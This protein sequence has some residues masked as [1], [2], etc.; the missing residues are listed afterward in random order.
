MKKVLAIAS[1]LAL[2]VLSSAKLN[3]VRI[4]QYLKISNRVI[5]NG[6]TVVRSSLD[7][8]VA[9]KS[10]TLLGTIDEYGNRRTEDSIFIGSMGF[11]L[12]KIP[13]AKEMYQGAQPIFGKWA[14]LFVIMKIEE[15]GA[16]G[17]NSYYAR[18]YNN[19][20]G[21]RCVKVRRT[22]S[23]KCGKYNYAM[24]PSWYDA[25][26]DWKIYLDIIHRKFYKKYK[27][28]AKDEFEVVDFLY[29][30]Y[31]SFPKWKRDLHWLLRNYK[32]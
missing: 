27:R 12:T 4:N 14:K 5:T 13:K 32:L 11:S 6:D 17:Q 8:M 21:M 15:S 28:E 10:D 2:V 20:C 26:V 23:H 16:D 9:I 30:Y 29:G 25:M 22:T 18:K 31:N 3:T 7:S 1:L 19:L 24:Y